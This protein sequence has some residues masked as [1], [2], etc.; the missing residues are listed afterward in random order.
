MKE[1]LVV[2]VLLDDFNEVHSDIADV[3]M[4]TFHGTFESRELCGKVLAGGVDTQVEYKG[5]KRSLSARY[6][7]EGEK[8]GNTYRIFVENNGFII[9]GNINTNPKV[10]TDC[11]ELK[12]LERASLCGT[13]EGAE[14]GVTVRIFDSQTGPEDNDSAG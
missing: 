2:H 5:E 9:D 10:I 1:V 4:I 7:L 14:G 3:T 8:N 12:Y 6:I 13:V 11:P